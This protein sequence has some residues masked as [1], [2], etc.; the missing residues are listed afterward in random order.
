V[1]FALTTDDALTLAYVESFS[2]KMRLALRGAGDEETLPDS[3]RVFNG[4]TPTTPQGQG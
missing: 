2:V 4:T 3:G 1:T